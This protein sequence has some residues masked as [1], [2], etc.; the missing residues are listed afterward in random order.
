[1]TY[2]ITFILETFLL[3]FKILTLVDVFL[4]LLKRSFFFL[5]HLS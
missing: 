3:R 5:R 2:L 4:L 1:M